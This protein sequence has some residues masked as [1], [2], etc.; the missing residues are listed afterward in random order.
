MADESLLERLTQL[1]G[2]VDK[3]LADSPIG[4]DA[5]SPA[6]LDAYWRIHAEVAEFVDSLGAKSWDLIDEK[7][8]LDSPTEASSRWAFPY[9]P[10]RQRDARPRRPA[11]VADTMIC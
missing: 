5:S 11:R 6:L 2:M 9:L 4:D 8:G 10:R 3:A 7:Y 1:K